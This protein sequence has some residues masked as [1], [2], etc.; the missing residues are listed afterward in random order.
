MIHRADERLI[1][2]EQAEL[3]GDGRL[4]V[5]SLRVALDGL[6]EHRLLRRKRQHRAVDVVEVVALAFSLR[7]KYTGAG[8]ATLFEL[9]RSPDSFCAVK[10]LDE[11]GQHLGIAAAQQEQSLVLVGLAG[12]VGTIGE[13]EGV[14]E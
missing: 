13:H 4:A 1:G 5:V 6:A 7:R 10:S 14:A 2:A 8:V 12:R 9:F 11:V 3:L